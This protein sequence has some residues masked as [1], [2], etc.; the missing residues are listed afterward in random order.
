MQ[1]QL[2]NL[3]PPRT[4]NLLMT[5]KPLI[6]LLRL[7]LT[8]LLLNLHK[9]WKAKHLPRKALNQRLQKK[10]LKNLQPSTEL[11]RILPQIQLLVRQTKPPQSHPQN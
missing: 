8:K 3:Q 5:L 9:K 4:Q 6:Q 7:S 1:H 10:L 11:P 2:K